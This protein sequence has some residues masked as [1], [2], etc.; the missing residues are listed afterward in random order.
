MIKL[1]LGIWIIDEFTNTL[2]RDT[3]KILAFNLHKQARKQGRAVIA[4]TTHKD[5][6]ADFA[7]NVH[8]HKRYG[9]EITYDITRKLSCNLLAHKSNDH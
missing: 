2:D 4:A 7:P 1:F 9:K 6:L 5:L 3:A 8:I